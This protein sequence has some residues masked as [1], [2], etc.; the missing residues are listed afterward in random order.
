LGW[1]NHSFR[2]V[3]FAFPSNADSSLPLGQNA[4]TLKPEC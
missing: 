1:K 4:E 3:P 2:D